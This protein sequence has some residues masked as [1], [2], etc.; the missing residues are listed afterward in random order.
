[1]SQFR[2]AVCRTSRPHRASSATSAAVVRNE[3]NCHNGRFQRSGSNR[4]ASMS[5]SGK[6]DGAWP[7]EAGPASFRDRLGAGPGC[8]PIP[9]VSHVV[10]AR[11][12]PGWPASGTK[13]TAVMAD[14]RN[15][16]NGRDGRP[17]ERS[18][19]P[20]SP[21]YRNEANRHDGRRPER[22]HTPLG[23]SSGTK[24]TALRVVVRNEA[25][26]PDGRR[27]ERSQPPRW[28]SSGTKPT[29]QMAVLRN[30]ANG[31]D[32]RPPERSQRPCSPSSGTKPTALLA[33]LRNEANGPAR[34][35]PE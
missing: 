16:A 3:A 32:G 5:I 28:P 22:S 20:C 34:R 19:R 8:T 2:C 25:N 21:S 26:R 18:Q 30:E 23:S 1:M 29:A 33:V 10:A 7:V 4:P 11:S 13:P 27:P 14:L 17:P 31:P 24:P 12:S 35:R 6:R 9:G 15:E